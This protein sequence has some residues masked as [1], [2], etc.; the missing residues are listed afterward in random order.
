[1]AD[2]RVE[3]WPSRAKG[4]VSLS[5]VSDSS[6]D[7]SQTIKKLERQSLTRSSSNNEGA[8]IAENRFDGPVDLLRLPLGRQRHRVR[9]R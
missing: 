3:K 7:I 2:V 1:M 5:Q 4:N 9:R 6:S 8:Q